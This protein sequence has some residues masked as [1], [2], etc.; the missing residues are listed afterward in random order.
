MRNR[1]DEMPVVDMADVK[2]SGHAIQRALDMGVE[3]SE[4]TDALTK[5][6]HAYWSRSHNA[7]CSRFGRVAVGFREDNDAPGRWIVLTVLWATEN[8]WEKDA[9]RAPLS[10]GRVV[11]RGWES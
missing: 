5:A 4:I 8:D 3:G 1:V 9:R 7:W 2:F 6:E 11:K 10:G